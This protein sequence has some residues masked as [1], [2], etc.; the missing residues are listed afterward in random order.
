VRICEDPRFE[1]SKILEAPVIF[2][3]GFIYRTDSI[4]TLPWTFQYADVAITHERKFTLYSGGVLCEDLR[5]KY[6][7][8]ISGV[9]S[10]LARQGVPSELILKAG[11]ASLSVLVSEAEKITRFDPVTL[12]E[13]R[14][15]MTPE[16]RNIYDGSCAKKK[17]IP[18]DW[19]C[20][21]TSI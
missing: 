2:A 8:T 20:S 17:K 12:S 13:I 1:I 14:G 11:M 16:V 6:D 5:L 21:I 19:K 10:E 3:T 15:K 7:T 18:N 9:M 4:K